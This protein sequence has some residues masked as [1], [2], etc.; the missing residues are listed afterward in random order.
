M[1]SCICN[2][3]DFI[4]TWT[5]INDCVLR[6]CIDSI[7]QNWFSNNSN[8]TNKNRVCNRWQPAMV[9]LWINLWFIQTVHQMNN[10]MQ[11][12]IKL[13]PMYDQPITMVDGTHIDSTSSPLTSSTTTTTN[14]SPNASAKLHEPFDINEFETF[15]NNNNTLMNNHNGWKYGDQQYPQLIPSYNSSLISVNN[16]N[17]IATDPSAVM[18]RGGVCS[19]PTHIARSIQTYLHQQQP[20]PI[21][22]TVESGVRM[23]IANIIIIIIFYCIFNWVQIQTYK[24]PVLIGSSSTGTTTSR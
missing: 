17:A 4:D 14:Q 22:V 20:P 9:L 1:F 3:I 19:P 5:I 18:A 12:V 13:R 11:S 24:K 2:V 21:N 15:N 7:E 23:V 10:G 16:S 6:C 8:S